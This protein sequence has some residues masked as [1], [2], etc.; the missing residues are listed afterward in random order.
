M[1]ANEIIAHCE[2]LYADTELKS[3]RDWKRA[4]PGRP[5]IGHLPV[6]APREIV[7]ACGGLPVGLA[8]AGDH[9]DIV[10]GDACFQS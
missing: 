4:H 10:K 5:A 3:V 6:Y 8:G 1:N 9:V 2:R 7:H